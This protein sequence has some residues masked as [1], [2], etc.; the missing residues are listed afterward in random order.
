MKFVIDHDLHLHSHLSAC[1][2]IPEQTTESFLVHAAKNRLKRLC[3]TDHFW[4]ELVPG[5]SDWYRPQNYA[6]ICEDLPLP[7]SEGI[8][9]H[10]GCETEM[11][12]FFTVGISK[13]RIDLFDFIIIPT[14]HLHMNGFTVSTEDNT[15]EARAR[16]FMEKNHALLDKDLPFEKI[17]LAH[18]TCGLMNKHSDGTRDQI[19]D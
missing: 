17:G 8:D 18:F 10:F 14:N 3:V 11:D 12:K 15:V 1:S 5:E 19:M 2:G 6:H 16:V 7:K 4:D 9:L 13:E